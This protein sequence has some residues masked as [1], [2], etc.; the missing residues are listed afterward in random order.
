MTHHPTAPAP[1]HRAALVGWAH[2]GVAHAAQIHYAELRPIPVH[3]APGTLPLTTDCSGFVTLCAK[4]AGCSDPNGLGFSGQGF[5]GTLL[6]HCNH[7]APE[8]ALPG[9]LIVYGPGSGH[10]VVLIVAKLPRGDFDCVSH[11]SEPDP[12]EL[13]HSVIAAYQPAPATFLRWL[14]P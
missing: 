8:H 4:W 7:I 3:D 12:R 6:G 2:W 1:S 10:H 13:R 5:T 11:G 9:D 14:D